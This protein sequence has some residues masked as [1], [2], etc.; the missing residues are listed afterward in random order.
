MQHLEGHIDFKFRNNKD[1]AFLINASV[2]GNRVVIRLFG[3]ID[4][5]KYKVKLRSVITI[6]ESSGG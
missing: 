6:F 3:Q 4:A 5:A 1:Y 2:E